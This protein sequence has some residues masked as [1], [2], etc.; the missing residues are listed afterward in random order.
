MDI[1]P[2]SKAFSLELKD[3]SLKEVVEAI[4]KQTGYTIVYDDKWSDL[5]ISGHYAGVTIEE[6]FQRSLCKKNVS[7]SYSNNGNV[8]NLRF[9]GD[10]EV[11][12]AKPLENLNKKSSNS[13]SEI[14]AEYYNDPESVDPMSGMKLSDLREQQASQLAEC[15]RYLN[16]PESVDPMNGMKLGDIRKQQDAKK[17]ELDSYLNDPESIDP[18]TGVKLGDLHKQQVARKAELDRYLN[19]PESIDP[20]TG[21]KLGDMKALRNVQQTERTHVRNDS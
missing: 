19:D 17:A 11:T 8:V 4:H 15:D 21:R 5:L 1:A 18:M 10:R 9:F 16:D 14:L 2:I 20:M 7:L 13:A 6:F 3:K 12:K